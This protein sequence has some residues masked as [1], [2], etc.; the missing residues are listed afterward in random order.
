[1]RA[2]FLPE[3]FQAVQKPIH[4]KN[5]PKEKFFICLDHIKKEIS[6]FLR[7]FKA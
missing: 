4:E 5:F 7:R 3:N 2:V 6:R 1:M